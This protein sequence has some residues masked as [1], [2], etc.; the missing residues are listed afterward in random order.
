MNKSNDNEYVYKAC[1]YCDITQQLAL[2]NQF[3]LIEI[4]KY[5]HKNNV[6]WSLR[7]NR[8]SIITNTDRIWYLNPYLND[9]EVNN[10]SF[11][12]HHESSWKAHYS[13]ARNGSKRKTKGMYHTE[14]INFPSIYDAIMYAVRHDYKRMA[15]SYKKYTNSQLNKKEDKAI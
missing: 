6:K 9:C 8:M 1:E 4:D 11:S 12:L 7:F 5:C 14:D 13:V 3:S 15:C 10:K 2:K